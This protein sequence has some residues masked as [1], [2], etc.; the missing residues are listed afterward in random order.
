VARS[1]RDRGGVKTVSIVTKRAEECSKY[2]DTVTLGRPIPA[3]GKHIGGEHALDCHDAGIQCFVPVFP[4]TELLWCS[5]VDDQDGKKHESWGK[6]TSS[7]MT[8]LVSGLGVSC[9]ER[10]PN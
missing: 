3:S 4:M 1:D 6:L 5:E 9:F 8:D 2:Q 10:R 7:R